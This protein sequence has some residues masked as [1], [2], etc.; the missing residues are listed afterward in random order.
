M[1]KR[2][3]PSMIHPTVKRTALTK[4][5]TF[6]IKKRTKREMYK[7]KKT[8]D[9]PLIVQGVND[10]ISRADELSSWYTPVSVWL[11]ARSRVYICWAE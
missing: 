2:P 8:S 4:T 3:H 6:L 11:T 10:T 9:N 1:L 7:K 5:H